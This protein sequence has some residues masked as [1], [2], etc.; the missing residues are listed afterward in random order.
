MS[1]NMRSLTLLVSVVTVLA[2]STAPREGLLK[3]VLV[4]THWISY[5]PTGYYPGESPP[6]LPTAES[7]RADMGVLRAAGFSGLITYGAQVIAVPRVAEDLG[8]SAMIVFMCNATRPTERAQIFQA[9]R[10]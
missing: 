6:V 5:A 2:P 7:L 3:D 10:E 8:F 1:D 9:V 4:D